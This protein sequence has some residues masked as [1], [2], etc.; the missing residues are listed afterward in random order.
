[1]LAFI[2]IAAATGML[3]SIA[4]L[5][6]GS[7][8]WAALALYVGAGMGALPLVLLRAFICDVLQEFGLTGK[9][10]GTKPKTNHSV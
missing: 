7:S 3:A 2:L 6:A 8:V 1:M 9:N 4:A 10:A 5:L